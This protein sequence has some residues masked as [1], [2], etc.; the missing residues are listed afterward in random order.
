[1]KINCIHC[2]CL[3]YTQSDG[4]ICGYNNHEDIDDKLNIE[5]DF[6]K[7]FYYNDCIDC[8]EWEV[9]HGSPCPGC[10]FI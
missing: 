9:K 5:T 7:D 10:E 8:D 6:C 3:V 2:S 4:I 1:M